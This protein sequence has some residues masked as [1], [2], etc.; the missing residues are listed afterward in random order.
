MINNIRTC[1]L[2]NH[3]DV[4]AEL[5]QMLAQ[6]KITLDAEEK[7]AKQYSS[8]NFKI[9]NGWHKYKK[10]ED[11]IKNGKN[12]Y[13]GNHSVALLIF[14]KWN[15]FTV[16]A[17]KE[18]RNTWN[19][20]DHTEWMSNL[21][22]EQSKDLFYHIL[23]SQKGT[24][25]SLHKTQLYPGVEHPN[26]KIAEIASD[27]ATQEE[28]YEIID[29]WLRNNYKTTNSTKVKNKILSLLLNPTVSE[30]ITQLH[31]YL[32]DDIS[33]NYKNAFRLFKHLQYISPI[34]ESWKET[35]KALEIDINISKQTIKHLL[36]YHEPLE[37]N[38]STITLPDLN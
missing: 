38:I 4:I 29:T 13:N 27:H 28:E 36:S 21:C 8:T 2:G 35:C 31:L 16:N 17:T 24:W 22:L 32:N 6:Y 30:T 26:W 18:E 9:N 12:K 33:I 3:G 5:K 7:N 34:A 23:S 14:N 11:I 1:L 37:D 10:Y 25:F 15:L 20:L 19:K